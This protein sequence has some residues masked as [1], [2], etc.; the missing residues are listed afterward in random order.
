VIHANAKVAL[1]QPSHASSFDD[2]LRLST[3]EKGQPVHLPLKR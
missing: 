3:L 1:L 2:W